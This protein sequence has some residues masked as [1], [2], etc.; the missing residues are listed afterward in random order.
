MQWRIRTQSECRLSGHLN[1]RLA[2]ILGQWA[3]RN[4]CTLGLKVTR[5]TSPVEKIKAT[6]RFL[7]F[8]FKEDLLN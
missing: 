1:N 6:L 2:N 3:I 8:N 4:K 7:I 5:L